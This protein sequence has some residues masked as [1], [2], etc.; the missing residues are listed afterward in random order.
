M[1]DFKEIVSVSLIL[2]SVIDMMGNI[3]IIINLR[4]KEGHIES[5]KATLVAGVIMIAFL[6]VGEK[7]LGLLGIDVASFAVAGALVIFFLG[8]EMILGITIF[9]ED[10]NSTSGSIVPLAFP[11]IAGAGSLTTIL[12]LK[13]AYGQF[14]I[15][16]G[17]IL[18]LVLV[19]AVLKGS[20]WIQSKL[21]DNGTG[22]LRKIFGIILLAISIRLFKDN[23]MNL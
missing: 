2:F 14:N 6:F 7:L 22:V 4:A 16:I 21:G 8:L 10:P 9:K 5:E 3:P 19:Y 11:L 12:S 1:F 20:K 15:L 18:N 13:A 17:I 23:I